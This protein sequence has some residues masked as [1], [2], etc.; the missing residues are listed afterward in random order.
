M[1]EHE[2]LWWSSLRHGGLLLTPSRL[3]ETFDDPLPEL[4]NYETDN[5]RRA[6]LRLDAASDASAGRGELVVAVLEDLCKLD[7]AHGAHWVAGSALDP[8]V[9]SRKALTGEVVRP[10]RVL[11]GP[12]GEI[13]PVFVVDAERVGAGHG[14]AAIARTLEWMRRSDQRLALI[15]NAR[16]W[17]L[18]YAATDHDAWA[19]WDT[20]QWFE[21]GRASHQVEALRRLLS[22][23]ALFAAAK[24]ERP[25]LLAA[26]EDSRKGQAELS[27][28]LGERVRKAVELLIQSHGEALVALGAQV[29]HREI[30]LAATRVVMR[31]VVVLFAEA[32]D[33][34][35]RE[36]PIYHG[37]YGLQGLREQLAAEGRRRRIEHDPGAWPRVLGL[38]RLVHEGSLHEAMPVLAYGGGL[39]RPG[40]AFPIDDGL[41]LALA[42]FEDPANSPHDD[43]VARLLDLLCRTRVKLR[44]GRGSMW[45]FS[46]VDFSDL[47]SE[48]IGI[49]YEGLLDFELRRAQPGDPMVFLALGDEPV[50][51]LSRLD[52]MP[53]ET[54]KGLLARFKQK[55]RKDDEEAEE[56]IEEETPDE[57]AEESEAELEP[58]ADDPIAPD[59]PHD[60]RVE[61]QRRAEDWAFRAVSIGAMVKKP[62]S[63]KPEALAAW[64]AQARSEAVRLVRRVILPGEWFLVRWGGTRKGSGTFYTPPQLAVPIVHRTLLPLTH[65]PPS[66]PDG[67][68]EPDAPRARWSPRRPAD[69]L[70][71]RV[72]DP[73]MGSGSFLVAALRFLTDALFES[74]HAHGAIHRDGPD[75]TVITL[76]LGASDDARLHNELLPC[77]PDEERFEPLLRTR[78]KRHVVTHCLY[79][80]DL[81]VLAVELACL[82]LWVETMDRELP[83]EFLDHRL[84]R[85][86]ALVG[87]WFDRFEDYPVLAWDRDG[88]DT[89]HDQSV[90]F[91]KGERTEKIKAFRNSVVLPAL[92]DVLS[93]QSRL[94]FETQLGETPAAV[95][96]ELR[97][98]TERIAAIAL[99]CPE[100]REHLYNKE[101]RLNPTYLRLRET[102]DTWCA[103]WF[104]PVDDLDLAP[105]PGEHFSLT[106]E[107]IAIVQR[108][109]RSYGFFHWE[110]EFPDVFISEKSGFDAVI[111]NPPWDIS[112]PKSWEYFSNL[113]PLYRTYTKRDAIQHQKALFSSNKNSETAWL[114]YNYRFNA[115]ANWCR[116][117]GNPF[118]SKKSNDG[119]GRIP[120][121]DR[122]AWEQ[123]RSTRI[124]YSDRPHPFLHQ[125][126]G[127]INS[128][129]LF[130]ELVAVVAKHA[131]LIGLITP[132]GICSDEG[133]GDLRRLLL[134]KFDWRFMIGFINWN[135]IFTSVYYRFKFCV[136]VAQKGTST[137][138]MRASFSRY[139]IE[140]LQNAES[141][142]SPYSIDQIRRFGGESLTIVEFRAERDLECLSR[143]FA[144]PTSLGTE[145]K[146]AWNPTYAREFDATNDSKLFS[147]RPVLENNG[148][149]PDNYDN[150]RATSSSDIYLPVYEGRMIGNADYCSRGWVSGHGRGAKWSDVDW[151]AEDRHLRPQYLLKKS[152]H[153]TR[154]NEIFARKP[155]SYRHRKIAFMDVG[156]ATNARSMIASMIGDYPCANS[157]PVLIG[158]AKPETLCA[159]L[160]SLPCDFAIRARCGGL[161]LNWFVVSPTPLPRPSEVPSAVDLL[162]ARLTLPSNRFAVNWLCVESHLPWI[163]LRSRSWRMWWAITPHERVRLRCMIDAVVCALYNL[164]ATELR[165]ILND[166]DHPTNVIGGRSLYRTL[167]PKGFWRVD[168]KLDPEL[169]Y[170]VLTQV[171][172]AD[173]LRFIETEGGSRDAGIAAFCAQH[174]GDGWMLPETLRLADYGL[175]HDERAKEP[176]KVAS[177]LGERFEAWQL[178]Q[179]PEESWAECERHARHLLGAEG[180]EWLKAAPRSEESR[181][182]ETAES[183]AVEAGATEPL[184]EPQLDLFGDGMPA[185]KKRAKKMRAKKG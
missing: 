90:H 163:N 100:E 70:A 117:V 65:T 140:D 107:A 121:G 183:A 6:L 147:E 136:F 78:L 77:R 93:K 76:P 19:E 3:I 39:F 104:W 97:A 66:A 185:K 80:V 122:R 173:L 16:Q 119:L 60:A 74:L 68:P 61:A 123:V 157:T 109:T 141:I 51:P 36:N 138:D 124:G 99:N 142:V 38:F 10:R 25:R 47:S 118:Q 115:M 126:G 111:G 30:Y 125:G 5:L 46:P 132:I 31:M 130:V 149:Q 171:A 27:A 22:P 168:K 134:T 137:K 148:F 21:G 105:L 79:G 108:L 146:D 73:A 17:R 35:P 143:I 133:S 33:L 98:V 45:V 158:A 92:R 184:E 95:H 181:V 55:K 7:A 67:S 106:E 89:K 4:S 1:T 180:Y 145:A 29:T 69:I 178:T 24:G 11:H 82:S 120:A 62:T 169:R 135:K 58:E 9:W 172:F 129:K 28:T 155:L 113:D 159:I 72:C 12:R 2:R 63:K 18:I 131:G 83:F 71:I 175:G 170:T 42:A 86:N 96:A 20:A 8:A 150:W 110:L 112:K 85:G 13:L 182:A 165:W 162:A 177:V 56:E 151:S 34:L 174:G 52:A 101:V 43:V 127:D 114:D 50:L 32:R 49:L 88:G 75:A 166:C 26:I 40:S 176:Q 156:S 57:E 153:L 37:S 64:E 164:S 94:S 102:F 160:T 15:T 139:D 87:C 41:G 116:N 152:K 161:H 128:Y 167:D 144:A 103:L 23:G 44:Q 48:Y 53:P 14:R 84:K 59:D 154:S 91:E 81:D 179:T 54:L